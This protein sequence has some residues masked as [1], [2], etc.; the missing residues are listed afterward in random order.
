MLTYFLRLVFNTKQ[1]GLFSEQ[2]QL[3]ILHFFQEFLGEAGRKGP[4]RI[5]NEVH[6][7]SS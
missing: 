1:F 3:E 7:K 4:M 6:S 2:F 5:A